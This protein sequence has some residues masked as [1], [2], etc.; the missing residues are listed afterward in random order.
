M[1]EL[2]RT[3]VILGLTLAGVGTLLWLAPQIPFLGRLPGD[4][5]IEREGGSFYFPITSCLV[6]SIL[7]SLLWNLFGR[8]R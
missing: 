5:R 8:G 3:L 2:A 4:L 7:L 1:S 6:I